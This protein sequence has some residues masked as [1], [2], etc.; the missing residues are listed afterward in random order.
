MA[1]DDAVPSDVTALRCVALVS[2]DGA[3][4]WRAAA[5]VAPSH[6][7]APWGMR[8]AG[9][10]ND[11]V[12]YVSRYTFYVEHIAQVDMSAFSD[13][14]HLGNLHSDLFEDMRRLHVVYIEGLGPLLMA[15]HGYDDADEAFGS[16]SELHNVGGLAL[17]DVAAEAF[18]AEGASNL[19]KLLKSAS[20]ARGTRPLIVSS[21]NGF[22]S[23]ASFASDLSSVL[24]F[25]GTLVTSTDSYGQV[26]GAL[27]EIGAGRPVLLVRGTEPTEEVAL[28]CAYTAL[29]TSWLVSQRSLS[30]RLGALECDV[31]SEFDAGVVQGRLVALNEAL[32]SAG[33]W[34]LNAQHY[35]LG[36]G[37]TAPA[38][39]FLARHGERMTQ[40]LRTDITGQL[41]Q[42][43]AGVA[44]A[45]Q[46]RQQADLLDEIG[47][48]QRKTEAAKKVASVVAGAVVVFT[49]VALYG[50]LAAVP[51]ENAYFGPAPYSVI[52]TLGI[53]LAG[54]AASWMLHVAA[55]TSSSSQRAQVA[56]RVV[57][58][59]VWTLLLVGIPIAAARDWFDRDASSSGLW[60]ASLL[61]L[62]TLFLVTT[63]GALRY[64]FDPDRA[65][66]Q[67]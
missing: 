33:K 46:A 9:A 59:S 27:F 39:E 25:E 28:V 56:R 13:E 6:G 29:S 43:A 49:L 19:A 11:Y 62:V 41:W 37:G 51:A 57:A 20:T 65:V 40:I 58:G 1:R 64:Q 34:S 31:L 12:E 3:E 53:L 7:F 35:L 36:D 42:R 22:G 67:T 10:K 38:R 60:A 63:Y 15:E 8:A 14:P 48:L 24:S 52:V 16:L 2:E 18:S 5:Q 21:A 50:T 44:A 30:E 61:L 54:G 32:G 26:N 45:I 17:R 47:D 55:A 66:K 23:P 4:A